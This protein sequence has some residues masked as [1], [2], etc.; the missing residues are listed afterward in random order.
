M[1]VLAALGM[2]GREIM[3][4]F[5]LEGAF[6]G[7]LGAFI[8]VVLGWALVQGIAAAGGIPLSSFTE[9]GGIGGDMMALMGDALLPAISFTTALGWGIAV[10]IIAAL[11]SLIPAWQ[12]AHSEPAEALHHV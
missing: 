3:G 5:L 2:K 1:G 10:M 9:Q 8:G 12:A 4:L 6:I 7:G 11:A